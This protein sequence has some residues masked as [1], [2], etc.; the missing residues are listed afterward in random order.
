MTI[1]LYILG[2]NVSAFDVHKAVAFGFNRLAFGSS[3]SL[4]ALSS[5]YL[6]A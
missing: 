4:S 3:C 1:P 2:G 6:M 5:I